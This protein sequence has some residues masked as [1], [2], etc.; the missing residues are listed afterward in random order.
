MPMVLPRMVLRLRR[1]L[2]LM[3]VRILLLCLPTLLLATTLEPDQ[4]SILTDNDWKKLWMRGGINGDS[5]QDNNLDTSDSPMF[6]D[7][8]LMAHNTTVQLGGTAFLVCKVSGVDRVGNQISWIRRRDWHILSSGAQL[9]TN[10]E[11]FAILHTPGS[12]MWTLQIKFVQRRDH[13]MYECQVSTPTGIISHFVNLQVVV[14]EAF[15]LG[16]GELHVDMGS[17]INLVCIIE[18]SPTPPQ[19][20]YW[21]KNDRLINYVDSRRDITIETTPGLRTQS[22]LIIRE[23]Q[24]TDSGNYSCSA[25]NTEPASIYVFVS[26]GDNMA[27]ISRRKT[28]S[29]DRLTHIFKSMLAPCFLLNTVIVRRIFLT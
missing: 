17:T 27:A 8:E 20:V 1:P 21:Q 7:S 13:G 9:Y 25:S 19:Y 15:I 28:S 5:K 4:K 29:A 26:K 11:R 14:P 16:S 24:I 12:N 23:P 18:K 6:E 22:R 2:N 10:D 3:E